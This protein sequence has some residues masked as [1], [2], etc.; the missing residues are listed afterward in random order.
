MCYENAVTFF[1]FIFA[2]YLNSGEVARKE[3][4]ATAEVAAQQQAVMAAMEAEAKHVSTSDSA[5]SQVFYF[6]LDIRQ[7][8]RELE[9]SLK[10]ALKQLRP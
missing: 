1:I 7:L 2:T 6:F 10:G 4:A 9:M 8:K 3:A 5:F